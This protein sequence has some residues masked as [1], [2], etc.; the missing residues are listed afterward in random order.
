MTIQQIYEQGYQGLSTLALNT[1]THQMEW[2]PIEDAMKRTS[3]TIGV[4][5]YL[6]LGKSQ[7]ISCD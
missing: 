3:K 5:V 2:K 7:I 1:K 6:K 4:R